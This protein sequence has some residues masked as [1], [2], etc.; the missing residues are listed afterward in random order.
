[1]KR[2]E[3]DI[4]ELFLLAERNFEKKQ[5]PQRNL[6]FRLKNKKNLIPILMGLFSFLGILQLKMRSI[7]EMAY[8]NLG[9]FYDSYTNDVMEFFS[10]IS[11]SM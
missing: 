9:L 4:Q 1:M 7:N 3:V 11:M 6:L 8:T 10:Y 2:H 5:V